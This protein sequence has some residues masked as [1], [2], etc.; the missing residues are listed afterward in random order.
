M[1][2]AR[3][4]VR[5]IVVSDGRSPHLSASLDGV[6][7]QDPVPDHVHLALTA[8]VE[9]PPGGWDP[10]I[11]VAS[12]D[13]ADFGSAVG[14][15]LE[16]NPGPGSELLW[17]LHD[18]TAAMEGA[19]AALSATA[20]KRQLAGVVGAAH[21]RWDAPDR[22]VSFG[23]TT[24]AVGARRMAMVE[25]DDVDQGQY[26]DRDDVL[27]V[28]IAGSLVRRE[29]WELLDGLD[30]GAEGWSSSLDF[31]RRAWR[32][33]YDVVAVPR[34][35]IRHSQ[36]RLEGRRGG[37][38]GGARATYGARRASE[39]YHAQ[40]FAPWWAV[41]LLGLWALASS[42]GRAVLRIA[43][44]EPGLLM[45][46]VLVPWRLLAASPHLP[47][48]R[49]NVRRAGRSTAA[50]RQLL[51]TPRDV[52]RHVRALEWGIRS[53]RR[54]DEAPTD[55][56]R[57]EL[58]ILGRRRRL[59]LA[60]LGIALAA[61]SIAL[62]PSW[63]SG[64]LGGR[65]LSGAAL[66]AT[67]LGFGALWDRALT[68]WTD[69]A[70]G[71][72]AIDG[73]LASLLLP[74]AAVPGGLALW[75]GLLL[76]LSP[77]LA[78]LTA[79][80]A[81]GAFTRSLTVRILAS[82]AYALWPMALE[83]AGSGRVAAVI[84]HVVAP[85]AVLALARAG[86]WHRGER[87]GDGSEHPTV[88]R[89]SRSAAAGAAAALSVIVIA[90][91]ALALVAL[92]VLIVVG[93]SAGRSRWRV[94]GAALPV[95]VVSGAGFVAAAQATS[96]EGAWSILTREPGP[97]AP[98]QA[99]SAAELLLGGIGEAGSVP[100]ALDV[101]VRVLPVVILG[102]AALGAVV[103]RRRLLSGL[104]ATTAAGALALAVAVQAVSL[105]P[106]AG[107][108]G[109]RTAGWYGPAMSVVV[110]GLLV[111]ATAATARSR[112]EN[113]EGPAQNSGSSDA[114]PVVRASGPMR[115]AA[116]VSAAAVGIVAV[117]AAAGLAWPGRDAAGDVEPVDVAVLPLVAALEQGADIR[118]RVLV[119]DET[120]SGV[121]YAVLD[122]DG[123]EVLSTAGTLVD[124]V[125]AVRL[126]ETAPVPG[127]GVL[128]EQIGALVLGG[129]ADVDA[130]AAWG[131]GVIVAA[132]GAMQVAD[133]LAQNP[134]LRLMGSADRGTSWRVG[135]AEGDD[136]V[137]VASFRGADGSTRSVPMGRTALDWDAPGAGTVTLAVAYDEDWRASLDGAD[138]ATTAD[139]SGRLTFAVADRGAVRVEFDDRGY[140][141]WFWASAAVVLWSL[142][143]AI[144]IPS[145]RARREEW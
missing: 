108:D 121:T 98:A 11:T 80:A 88:R 52:A 118:Q 43:Q 77:L 48:S 104:A 53:R 117:G 110:I 67:D 44:N 136:R 73:S 79:W 107:A 62:H 40:A 63:L 19:L 30:A 20:R 69:Q 12:V 37:S 49:R 64:L 85:L 10:R 16:Q 75:L 113:G 128:G 33:G 133:V 123:T 105:S 15:V 9:S 39:W 6:F 134:D 143:A 92:P 90:V 32:A 45:A 101:A 55:V 68:G 94:W 28:S 131:I 46:D 87:L 23:T 114:T 100:T 76:L 22:L 51:A 25:R 58:V 21:V 125:P 130:L 141:V 84:V 24:T 106:D 142:V 2:P 127:P 14:A 3:I 41:P 36:E 99:L 17:L 96:L 35:R 8:P 42:A 145:R 126:P 56:V 137:S 66:G 93:A 91:P 140:R 29:L 119:V 116:A 71:A 109:A 115:V 111:V 59:A 7:A 34:A 139:A 97:S 138:V 1:S 120:D 102:A 129:A 4:V 31:C 82:A 65:M 81:T 50:E 5:A 124:G 27:A 74:L 61:F 135:A 38:G 47:R 26:A 83:S 112:R 54:A 89:P 13:A 132:P 72:P 86:G 78:G 103:G 144:P 60:A 18:D 95:V 57:A 122:H 70:F